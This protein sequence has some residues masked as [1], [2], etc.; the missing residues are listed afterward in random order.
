MHKTVITKRELIK[1]L[2]NDLPGESAQW[3]MAPV[4]RPKQGSNANLS[5]RKA[6]VLIAFRT[7]Q[8]EPHLI[9]TL[10]SEYDGIHSAQVSFPGGKFDAYET[11]PVQVA[12]REMEEE[13]GV[14]RS[15]IEVLGMLSPLHIPVSGMLVQPVVGWIDSDITFNPDPREVQRLMQVGYTQL[16]SAEREFANDLIPGSGNAFQTPYL[17]LDYERVWGAT[18]M[19]LSE[20][21]EILGYPVKDTDF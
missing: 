12:L 21:L 16:I 5:Y 1:Y 15:K 19:M 14:S 20:L 11:D 18:A 4:G 9:M 2:Q 7:T 6:A 13:T 8:S 17:K 10:R 3:K